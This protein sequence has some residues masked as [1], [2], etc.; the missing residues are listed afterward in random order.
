[1]QTA[2]A[3]KWS[4]ILE[5][6]AKSDLSLRG[7]ASSRGINPNTLSWWKWKLGQDEAPTRGFLEVVVVEPQALEVRLGAARI[8]VEADTDLELLRRVVEVLS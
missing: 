5:Q 2:T 3:T 7:F 4:F 8:Q 6:A 1:M